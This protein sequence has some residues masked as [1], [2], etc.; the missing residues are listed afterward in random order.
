MPL[1]L[2]FL[3]APH[4]PEEQIKKT[5]SKIK[6]YDLSVIPCHFQDIEQTLLEE[7]CDLALISTFFHPQHFEDL[8]RVNPR[9]RERTRIL[10]QLN[11]HKTK[12]LAEGI[13]K[14]F[15]H[16][17]DGILP[18]AASSTE[19]NYALSETS[20]GKPYLSS[21]ITRHL[22]NLP[23]H[24]PKPPAAYNRLSR[25][26]KQVFTL[27]VNTMTSQEIADHL[28]ISIKTVETHRTR[29]MKKLGLSRVTELFRFAASHQLL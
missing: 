10:I 2:T 15:G 4:T 21:L 29:M 11:E 23:F 27:V 14:T 25:R 7:C 20:L 18:T 9:I 12:E 13:S 1:T 5:V 16:Q 22:L 6:S 8:A 19:I 17:I 28:F 24:Q 3:Y 26:E